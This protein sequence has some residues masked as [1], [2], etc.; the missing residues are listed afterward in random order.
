MTLQLKAFCNTNEAH[1][2]IGTCLQNMILIIGYDLRAPEEVP[3]RTAVG[4]AR[5]RA[6]GQA[7]TSTLHAS[8][9]LSN[10]GPAAP[11][12]TPPP[13]LLITCTHKGDPETSDVFK[14][15]PLHSVSSSSGVPGD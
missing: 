4:A 13:Y 1:I 11:P 9:R 6:Q 8:C 2:S 14:N 15:C 5:P 7:T 10:R 3:T 12:T